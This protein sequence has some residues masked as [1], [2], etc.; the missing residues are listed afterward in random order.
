MSLPD[1]ALAYFVCKSIDAVVCCLLLG[2]ALKLIVAGR[3]ENLAALRQAL[4]APPLA[5][6]VPWFAPFLLFNVLV[7]ALGV[8]VAAGG[9]MGAVEVVNHGLFPLV[10][11]IFAA[12]ALDLADGRSVSPRRGS[13]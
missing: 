7:G 10:A 6:G 13:E 3:L 1:L 2:I 12:L 9:N 11:A 4:Q 5:A 8:V